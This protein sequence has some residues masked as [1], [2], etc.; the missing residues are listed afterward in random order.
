MVSASGNSQQASEVIPLLSP[1]RA[2]L[3]RRRNASTLQSLWRAL[4]S[5]KDPEIPAVSLWDLGIL[6]D[7]VATD[8]GVTVV[9]T[10]TYSGC[11]AMA[12]MAE[13]IRTCLSAQGVNEVRVQTRLSPAWS[14]D[15]LDQQARSALLAYG[16]APPAPTVKAA[17]TKVGCPHCGSIHT[18]VISEFGSTACKALYRCLDCSEPFD[19]FKPI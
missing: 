1:E 6:Q 2:E 3:V 18:T 11:P 12:T 7:I 15:W 13:D 8:A 4:D 17:D 14:T 10:P 9:I 5:V 19:Y 16:I